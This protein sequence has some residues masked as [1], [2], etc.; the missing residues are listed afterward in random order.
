MR[1]AAVMLAVATACAVSSGCGKTIQK[2][3]TE[4]L[5]ASDAVD[6][7]ISKID[8]SALSGQK[9]YFDTQYLKPVKEI[10]FVNSNYITSALR[11]QMVAAKCRLQS[12]REDADFICEARVGALGND[13]NQIVY[14][15]PA[16]NALTAVAAMVPNV[17]TVP[18]IPEISVARRERNSAVAKVA[19]FAY[20]RETGDPIWQSGTEVSS[21]DEKDL[22]LFGAGPFENG[23]IHEE[24]HLAGSR[25][26]WP[27]RRKETP[28]R[29]DRPT[30]HGEFVFPVAPP[31][32]PAAPENGVAKDSDSSGEKHADVEK[33]AAPSKSGIEQAAWETEAAAPDEPKQIP[34]KAL[35]TAPKL[36]ETVVEEAPSDD[37]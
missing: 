3:G 33:P 34:L 8:F 17:P 6:A 19:V 35:V 11:Q 20:R 1:R 12:K 31:P 29:R 9:V 37:D 36:P 13:Q 25:L 16:N 5:L 30:F 32:L 26:W 21:S 24:T 14:G 23:T 15:I 4:Q 10:G 28:R 2:N 18:T 22:W 27:F 7:S